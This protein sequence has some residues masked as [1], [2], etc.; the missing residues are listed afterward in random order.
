MS[1]VTENGKT[2]VEIFFSNDDG[3]WYVQESQKRRPF[4]FRTSKKV[5]GSYSDARHAWLYGSVRWGKWS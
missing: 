1:L 3:G 4:K 2:Y 5:Y